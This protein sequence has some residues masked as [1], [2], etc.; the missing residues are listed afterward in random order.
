VQRRGWE[1]GRGR[2]MKMR[3]G[4]RVGRGGAGGGEEGRREEWGG[5]GGETRGRAEGGER[6]KEVG[7][8]GGGGG[9]K[10]G[11]KRRKVG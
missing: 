9:E 3:G 4:G 5:G 8:G 2:R 10:W 1:R 11:E 6:G 7:F